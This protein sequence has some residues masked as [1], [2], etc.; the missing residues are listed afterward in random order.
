MTSY[1]KR[2]ITD[3]VFMNVLQLG[4]LKPLIDLVR[5]DDDLDFQIRDNYFNIYFKGHSLLKLESNRRVTVDNKFIEGLGLGYY[6]DSDEAVSIF[7]QN[8]PNIKDRITLLGKKEIE[9]EYEQLF[10]R[11]NNCTIPESEYF[12]LDRQYTRSDGSESQLDMVGLY[13]SH[14]NRQH[15]KTVP[16]TV[17]EIK[18]A[19]NPDIKSVD[20]QLQRYYNYVMTHFEELSSEMSDILEQKTALRTLCKSKNGKRDNDLGKLKLSPKFE[21]VQFILV[22]VDY[23]PNGRHLNLKNLKE[24]QFNSQIKIFYAGMALWT[25]FLMK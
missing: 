23:N 12:V 21:D 25:Q 19:D 1:K 7:L 20:K 11:V 3:L 5:N 8:V 13:W 6:L 14:K 18:Y 10:I 4:Q 16:L 2:G 24:L 9:R 22:L 15:N 17:F